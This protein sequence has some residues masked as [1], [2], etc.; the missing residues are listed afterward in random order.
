[1]KDISHENHEAKT[2][3]ENCLVEQSEIS[4]RN[5]MSEERTIREIKEIIDKKRENVISK[6]L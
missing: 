1:M 3:K 4:V 5:E 2:V 6:G